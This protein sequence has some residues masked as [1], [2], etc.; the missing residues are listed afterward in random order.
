M[1][2]L[3]IAGIIAVS[4]V[5]CATKTQPV[6][7]KPE[8]LYSPSPYKPPEDGVYKLQG[9]KGPE[10]MGSQEVVEASRQCIMNKMQPN[11]HYLAVRTDQG[12]TMV[13]VNVICN[14]F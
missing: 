4:L 7:V 6:A 8:T 9:Y 5:G 12:K 1:K 14:P 10:A 3:V 2:Q 11:V 13:P